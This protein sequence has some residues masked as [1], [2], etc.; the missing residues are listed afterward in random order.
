M[1]KLIIGAVAVLAAVSVN[2]ASIKWQSGVRISN[3]VMS[4]LKLHGEPGDAEILQLD[5]AWL[6]DVIETDATGLNVG[7]TSQEKP[8][9]AKSGRKCFKIKPTQAFDIIPMQRFSLSHPV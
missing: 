5:I 6:H 9:R 4:N 7:F 3:L 8:I 2:A 1:K